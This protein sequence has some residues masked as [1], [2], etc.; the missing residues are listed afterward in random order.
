MQARRHRPGPCC[1]IL[2]PHLLRHIGQNGTPSQRKAAIDTLATD[3]TVRL[4]RATY[5]L[6]EASAHQALMS[7]SEIREQRTIYDTDHSQALPGKPV[8]N[9]TG[10]TTDDHSVR[11]AFTGLGATFDFYYKVYSRNSIDDEGLHLDGT[12]HYGERYDNAFWNGQQMV[13][14]DGDGELFNRFTISLDVIGHELTHGVTGDEANLIYLGQPGALNESISDVFGSL[15]KQYKL[16]QTADKADW[17]I[18]AELLAPGVNGVALRSMKSPGTAY[19]DARLGKDPQ[20]ADMKDYVHTN[21]DNSGVHINSGIPNRAFC[22]LALALGG[23]AWEKAGKIWYETLRDKG[24]KKTSSFRQF[25]H[26]T[27]INAGHLFGS[28]STE[29]KAV[30]ECWNE[31]GIRV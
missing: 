2:P 1:F 26:R 28:D 7:A 31:V 6:L 4:T 30:V 12:V 13:F 19:D 3:H 20:P 21:E 23:N 24:L 8:A 16:K 10:T 22:L 11:E 18:G 9:E 25:A 14:G 15:V 29:A 5:Q 27:I 17:L